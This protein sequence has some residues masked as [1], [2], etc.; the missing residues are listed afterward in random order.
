MQEKTSQGNMFGGPDGSPP[1]GAGPPVS[2]TGHSGSQ[3]G[4]TTPAAY[5]VATAGRRRA[6]G[7][8]DPP[9]LMRV[10]GRSQMSGASARVGSSLARSLLFVV[11]VIAIAGCQAERPRTAALGSPIPTPDPAPISPSAVAS[12]PLSPSAV[13]RALPSQSAEAIS[14]EGHF[15]VIMPTVESEA[16]RVWGTLQDMEFFDKYGYTSGLVFPSTPLM[17]ELIQKGRDKTLRDADYAALL[18]AMKTVYCAEDYEGSF[19]KVVA[20][21]AALEK[22]IPVFQK[23][24]SKWQFKTFPTYTVQLTHFGT[25]GSYD[26]ENGAVILWTEK[27]GTLPVDILGVILHE[28]THI[29]I[30]DL[31]QKYS[32]DQPVKERI[33]DKFVLTHFLSL[34]PDYQVQPGDLTDASI[35]RYLDSNDAW[36]KLPERLTDFTASRE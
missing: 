12:A 36:D 26:P 7:E 18:A 35:D 13:A 10:L 31:V 20:S 4:T 6:T 29:G 15:K 19:Q 28:A 14:A 33:V 1:P 8:T 11:L 9:H 32:L 34:D 30:E 21:F 2:E 5:P 25:G 17:T 3:R 24:E 16:D 22:G 23:Y 27:S